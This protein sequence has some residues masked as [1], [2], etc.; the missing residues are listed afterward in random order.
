VGLTLRRP[1][2]CLLTAVAFMLPPDLVIKALTSS[3]VTKPEALMAGEGVGSFLMV[4]S[5]LMAAAAVSSDLIGGSCASKTL[6]LSVMNKLE[7]PF[8][9]FRFDMSWGATFTQQTKKTQFSEL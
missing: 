2:K 4:G 3:L 1:L 9:P 6:H 8:R 7:E 5:C